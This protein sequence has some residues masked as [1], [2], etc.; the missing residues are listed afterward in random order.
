MNADPRQILQQYWGFPD[1]RP[2]QGDIIRS[3]LLGNDTLALM[4]TGG[5]KSLCFQVPALAKEGIC[6]VISPLV[7]LMKDQ[8]DR[9][10]SMD[11]RAAYITSAQNFREIDNILDSAIYGDTK[12]L[13]VS[14]ERLRNE[15]FIERFRQMK[16]NLIAVD[17]AHCISQWG[18]DFR[19]AYREIK[20]IRQYH[21]NVP[22]LAVTA[23]ATPKVADDIC[24]QLEL[25][26]TARFELPMVRS[27]LNYAVLDVPEPLGRLL[28]I[29]RRLPGSGI[30]YGSTRKAV[31]N[32]S[33]FLSAHEVKSSYYHAGLDAATK[34]KRQQDWLKDEFDVMVATNA[35][36]MGIDKSDVRFVVHVRPPQN[37]EN[38]VQE[39]G[40]AG[41]DSKES[42]AIQLWNTEMVEEM[43]REL[44]DRFPS[45]ESIRD[46]YHKLCS[47]LGIA[48]AAGLN[49]QYSF[50]LTRFCKHYQLST[51]DVHYQLEILEKAEYILISEGALLPSRAMFILKGQE[52]Y[53]FQVRH[54]EWDPFIRLLLRSYGGMF[55]VYSRI[56]EH[57]LARK[58]GW[59]G[60]KVRDTLHRLDNMQVLSYRPRT[61]V[62]TLT[63]LTG[64]QQKENLIIPAEAYEDRKERVFER[65]NTML[66]YLHHDS[67]RSQFIANYFG[68]PDT[69]FCGHCDWCRQQKIEK[70]DYRELIKD[71]LQQQ[72]QDLQTLIDTLGDHPREEIISQIHYSMDEGEV[73]KD[74][75]DRLHWHTK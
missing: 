64:R 20:E 49:E 41:R 54:S 5:G 16:V 19:P 10:R 14:P 3:V 44:N 29:C 1:F 47:F 6:I 39:A 75:S 15:L 7:A 65:W 42:W 61:E 52:L 73:L 66:E 33:E 63:M 45:K 72:P 21:P 74:D 13:Y 50:D 32:I 55:E 46:T 38:Y 59:S 12:F 69:P 22:V 26:D 27:N 8:V 11:I 18:H 70:V 43:S 4:P 30:V 57:F 23:S 67:C 2:Q 36:G 17:E 40:R 35:F 28:R 58:T 24:E 37:L 71:T 51:R 48:F 68:D 53:N 62:P 60:D 31:R 9:L 56:D 34:E 25:K